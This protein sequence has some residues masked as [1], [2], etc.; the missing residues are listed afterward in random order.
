MRG[1]DLQ[2]AAI[3]VAHMKGYIAAHFTSV[4]DSRGFSRTPVA[5]DGKGWPDLFLVGRKAVAVEVK[6][7]GDSLRE[8]QV[9]WLAALEAA[10]IE[11]LVLTPKAWRDGELEML[12]D[13]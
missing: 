9:K 3:D 8:D 6:G 12:L 10:G 5:A 11:T 7:T 2:K 1:K 4:T 13:G